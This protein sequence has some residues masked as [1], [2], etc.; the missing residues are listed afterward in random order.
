MMRSFR[1]IVSAIAV[2]AIVALAVSTSQAATI[3]KMN[4]SSVGPDVAMNSAGTFGT[5]SD[6][7]AATTGDQNTDVEFTGFLDPMFT[8]ITTGDA[9]FTISGPL[10]A[11]PAPTAVSGP[12]VVQGF[13]SQGNLATFSLYG[14]GNTLLL[15]GPT[16]GGT[17]TGTLGPPGTGAFFTTTLQTV[18]GGSLAPLIAP[19]SVSLSI[20]LT[21]INGGLGLSLNPLGEIQ[22]NSFTSDGFV[23]ISADQVPEPATIGMILVGVMISAASVRRSRR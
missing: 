9:S 18:T 13:T 16:G 20:N 2:C 1:T 23:S 6:G 21:N 17:L 12:V 4:L 19:G 11:N 5:T 3:L 8:D 22:L 15:K 7:I 14:P 10:V